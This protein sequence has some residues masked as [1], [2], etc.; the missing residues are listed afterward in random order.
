M[1]IEGWHIGTSDDE[2]EENIK[3]FAFKSS[4][5]AAVNEQC[6]IGVPTVKTTELV[7]LGTVKVKVHKAY[8]QSSHAKALAASEIKCKNAGGR[9]SIKLATGPSRG[10]GRLARSIWSSSTQTQKS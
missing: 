6:G 8:L 4:T 5:H 2:K 7:E 9:K 10:P 1:E 3:Q